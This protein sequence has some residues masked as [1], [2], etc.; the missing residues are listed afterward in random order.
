MGCRLSILIPTL[1]CRASLLAPLMDAL[2]K[3]RVESIEVIT[4][5]DDGEATT[6][7]KRNK[8]MEMA[9]G[10]WLVFVDDDDGVSDNYIEKILVALEGNPDVVTFKAQRYCDGKP[11]GEQIMRLSHHTYEI[12]E[13]PTTWLF[14]PTHLCPT[15]SS[16]AKQ[17]QFKDWNRGEDR[18]WQEMVFPLLKSEV[19]IPEFLYHYYYRQ[20]TWHERTNRNLTGAR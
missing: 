16:L 9:T 12:K 1:K 15:R 4:L 2:N 8:L 18:Q 11:W 10:E 6:G 3:Q 20:Q 7:T 13:H 19:H 17:L 14:P 5:E